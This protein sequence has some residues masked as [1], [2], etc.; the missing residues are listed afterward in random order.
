MN[1]LALGDLAKI[2]EPIFKNILGIET[3]STCCEIDLSSMRQ[4]PTDE[5]STLI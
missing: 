1:S 2:L 4:N 5:M 3:L